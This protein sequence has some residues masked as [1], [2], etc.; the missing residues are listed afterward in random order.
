MC[1]SQIKLLIWDDRNTICTRKKSLKPQPSRDDN[2][3]NLAKLEPNPNR[4]GFYIKK[5]ESNLLVSV[6]GPETRPGPH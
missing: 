3:S 4:A 1:K 5:S 6:L 2:G